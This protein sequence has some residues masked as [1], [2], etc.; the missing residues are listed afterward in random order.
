MRLKGRRFFVAVGIGLAAV[1]GYLAA[2]P[3]AARAPAS[4]EPVVV[5]A[6]GDADVSPVVRSFLGGKIHIDNDPV[7]R[8]YLHFTLS[9]TGGARVATLNVW[10]KSDQALGFAVHATG[11]NWTQSALRS[12]NAPP[13]GTLLG[14]SGPVA[15]NTAYTFDVPIAGDGPVAFELD[16]AGDRAIAIATSEGAP[17]QAPTLTFTPGPA[18]VTSTTGST[19][20]TVA[21]TTTEQTTTQETTTAPTTSSTG[22][23]PTVTSEGGGTSGPSGTIRAAFYYPWFPAAWNQQGLSPFTHYHPTLGL[24]DGAASTVIAQQ[25][26]W[27]AEAGLNAA[28]ASWWGPGSNTDQKIPTILSTLHS[29]GSPLKLSLY[30]EAGNSTPSGS[31]LSSDLTYI[32]SHYAADSSFLHV[33]GKPVLFV[34][35]EGS[36]SA[37]SAFKTASAGRFYLDLKVFTGFKMCVDQPDGW[38]QYG[39]ATAESWQKGYSFTISPG[40]YKANESTPRLARDPARWDQNVKDMVASGERWQ[41]ITTFNEWGE[42]TSVEAATEWQSS[43]GLGTYLDTVRSAFSA[44]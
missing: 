17:A 34:Y 28:I 38:H 5:T 13:P 20:T 43:S 30:Y 31:Q 41:L 6:D 35:N 42:G 22:T 44:G 7:R 39:P 32:Y 26:K 19:T 18:R 29:I 37:A 36:C 11:A 2:R 27:L 3:F 1:G 10:A 12:T 25:M 8:G 33:D 23:T 4:D 24:Y 21:T 15:A 9:G 40:F 16:T 14:S